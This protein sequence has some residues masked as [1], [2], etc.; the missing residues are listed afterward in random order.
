LFQ[1]LVTKLRLMGELMARRPA[2]SDEQLQGG[3][4]AIAALERT[5]KFQVT[6]YTIEFLAQKVRDEEYYVPEYQ[7]ELTWN[8]ENQSRF[9]ESLLMGLPIPF[10]FLWQA[11]DGRLEIVDGSQRLRTIVR[12]MDNELIREP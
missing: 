1:D 6:D 4:T 3:E 2:F 9:I 10:L 11:E 5:V 8:T 12:F 7:R